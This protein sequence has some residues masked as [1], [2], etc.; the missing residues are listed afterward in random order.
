MTE[1]L[2]NGSKYILATFPLQYK[3]KPLVLE[4]GDRLEEVFSTIED[5]SD[6]PTYLCSVDHW[7]LPGTYGG[8][9]CTPQGVREL[10]QINPQED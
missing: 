5:W 2:K 7:T 1:V 4:H 3:G 8:M 9:D 6:E 10:Y